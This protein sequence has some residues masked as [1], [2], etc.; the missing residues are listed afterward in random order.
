MGGN[1]TA[2]REERSET[3]LGDGRGIVGRASPAVLV[4]ELVDITGHSDR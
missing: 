1:P 3:K 2:H 4:D